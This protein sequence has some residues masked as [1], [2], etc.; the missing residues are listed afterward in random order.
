VVGQL[1]LVEV[2]VLYRVLHEIESAQG[3]VNLNDLSRKLGIEQS[4]LRGMLSFWVRKGRLQG[5]P[6][7]VR[8]GSCAGGICN[9]FCSSCPLATRSTK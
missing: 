4:T 8:A 2:R 7:A 5:D 9:V 1:G 3:A 6:L